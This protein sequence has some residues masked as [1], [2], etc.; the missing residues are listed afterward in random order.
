MIKAVL[1]SDNGNQLLLIGLSRLN[2]EKLLEGK[3]ILFEIG[4]NNAPLRI[5]IVGGEPEEAIKVQVNEEIACRKD[6]S[7]LFH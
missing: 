7:D 2:M 5:A 6:R 4:V 1:S 3:P